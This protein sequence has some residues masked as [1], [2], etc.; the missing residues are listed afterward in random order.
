MPR[1]SVLTGPRIDFTKLNGW[2]ES[3]FTAVARDLWNR[4]YASLRQQLVTGRRMISVL[5]LLSAVHLWWFTRRR[6]G[7]RVAV[8]AVIVWC[9]Y[10]VLLAHGQLVTN[11]F[12]AGALALLVTTSLV[13]YLERPTWWR[14]ACLAL[15][16][17]GAALAKTSLL[18][19]IVAVAAIVVGSAIARR[20]GRLAEL[21]R[22]V[23]HVAVVLAT[24]WLGICGASF[25]I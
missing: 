13:A 22:R 10:T 20:A 23:P 14:V 12:A 6:M 16:C 1:F 17:A 15:A 19:L 7:P 8:A 18:L 25:P 24:V 5:L 11:D 21:K 4:D 3:D 9:G 2:A